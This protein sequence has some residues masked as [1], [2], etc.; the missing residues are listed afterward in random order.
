MLK[1]LLSALTLLIV[2]FNG[3]TGGGHLLDLPPGA[4]SGMK[5]PQLVLLLADPGGGEASVV[6]RWTRGSR[7]RHGCTQVM[8]VRLNNRLKG[9]H[10]IKPH[11]ITST[12][13]S[14]S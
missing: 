13:R 11:S 10:Q 8:T 2:V 12:P 5:C 4:F 3:R 9:N 14:P 7:G 6:L 1:I